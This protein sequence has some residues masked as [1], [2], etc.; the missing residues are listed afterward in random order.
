M[1]E[2]IIRIESQTVYELGPS[3]LWEERL[4]GLD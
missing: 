3:T 4:D 2:S 1:H